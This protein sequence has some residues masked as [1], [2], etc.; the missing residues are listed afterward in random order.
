MVAFHSC[1]EELDFSNE[2]AVDS[3]GLKSPKNSGL[4]PLHVRRFPD[5][6]SQIHYQNNEG[7]Y[8]LD[9]FRAVLKTDYVDEGIKLNDNVIEVLIMQ[10]A[11]LRVSTINDGTICH[12][13]AMTFIILRWVADTE[14]EGIHQKTLRDYWEWVGS[15]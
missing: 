4:K 11:V 3:I 15:T 12:W 14:G 7:R 2:M 6:T 5:L 10:I 9:D 1:S 8:W 13:I